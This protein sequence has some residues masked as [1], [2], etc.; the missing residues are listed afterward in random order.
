MFD[1]VNL[2]VEHDFEENH[3]LQSDV[4]NVYISLD[5]GLHDIEHLCC[6]AHVRANFNYAYE[7][8][9]DERSKSF[10]DKFG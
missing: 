8:V 4:Y 5:N 6:M 10:L 9:N 3:S 1:S 2:I 7:Q